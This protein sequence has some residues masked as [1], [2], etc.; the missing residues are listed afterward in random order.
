MTTVHVGSR[1]VAELR[2]RDG[3]VD[4]GGGIAGGIA[5]GGI[6]AGGITAGELAVLLAAALRIATLIANTTTTDAATTTT[7]DD[8]PNGD[9]EARVHGQHAPGVGRIEHQVAARDQHLAGRGAFPR[10]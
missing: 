2:R 5:G 3:E 8:R 1:R 7:I 4:R 6:I 9:E 10:G